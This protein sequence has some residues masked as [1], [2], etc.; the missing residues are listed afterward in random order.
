LNRITQA[1]ELGQS[2]WLD[3]IRRDLVEDG[4][5]DRL[6][7]AGEIRGVT[8]NPT[9]FQQ[10]IGGG[11]L[12]NAAIRPLAHAGWSA[13]QIYEALAIHDIRA[14]TDLFLPL[15]E[16]TNAR[17]GYVSIEVNPRLANDSEATIEEARRLW[18]QVN[19][20]NLMVKIPATSGGIPAI[21]QSIFE[22]INV[23]VT[24]IFALDR[25]SEVMDA[26]LSGL[27]RRLEEGRPLERIASVASFFVSR[28]DT[29][30]DREL[31]SIVREEGPHASRAMTLLG[32]AAVANAKLAYAQFQSVFGDPRFD[33][34]AEHGARLQ[35][36]LWASTST[37]NAAY[38]DVLYVDELIGPDTVNTLPPKTLEAFR[39]H[40][41]AQAR[42][43]EDLAVARAQLEA[44]EVLGVSMQQVTDRLESE[45][46][47]AFVQSFDDLIETVG[48]RADAMRRELGGL[49]S[50]LENALNQLEEQRAAG[51]YWRKDLSLWPKARESHKPRIAEFGGGL[52]ELA[53][54]I[55]RIG[56]EIHK[57]TLRR[58]AWIGAHA[59]PVLVDSRGGA[60]TNLQIETAD[61]LEYRGLSRDATAVVALS[62]TMQDPL[63]TAIV[64]GLLNRLEK[65]SSD[66][67]GDR[68]V[69][70][71]PPDSALDGLAQERGFGW[72][73]NEG[74]AAAVLLQADLAAGN[75]AEVVESAASMRDA[76][77]QIREAARNPGLYLGATLAVAL[78]QGYARIGLVADEAMAPAARWLADRL[79]TTGLGRQVNVV[80]H[81]P[82]AT[83]QPDRLLIYLRS[84]GDL[85]AQVDGWIAAGD[86]VV[87]LEVS[88]VTGAIGG[89][90]VRW[91]MASAIAAYLMQTDLF[92][93][94]VQDQVTDRLAGLIRKRRKG[95]LDLPKPTW[96]FEQNQVWWPQKE[97][98]SL[99]VES[100][101]GLLEQ[102]LAGM[103]PGTLI[104]LG[105]YR[106]RTKAIM[107]RLEQLR[108]S[109]SQHRQLDCRAAFGRLPTSTR[110]KEGTSRQA[111]MLIEEP[112]HKDHQVA[113]LQL[114]Y[115]DLQRASMLAAVDRLRKG[116]ESV[117]A[118][119]L[120]SID[121]ETW[122]RKFAAIAAS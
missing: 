34:L 58:V 60:E 95:R 46:V 105:I 69:A 89:E 106:R 51:R 84:E 70:I 87:I 18:E 32:S 78:Q 82:A 13:N 110:E 3:Y 8:S 117:C 121:T 111:F 23:N 72:V 114:G 109:L 102:L 93:E 9:I 56:A 80:P 73:L 108:Q 6:I 42:L 81:L 83:D 98:A 113:S 88:M 17:D 55:A 54:R 96:E 49:Q 67:A 57:S 22:G 24:L 104:N 77:A 61:P 97:S 92:P 38:S 94:T 25:Y 112:P 2:F 35:R 71:A 39:D 59:L 14:A 101:D 120:G 122:L 99:E 52:Q 103:L 74:T 79:A 76:C 100:L 11:D 16:G 41:T 47:Q 86:P 116:R 19:R 75:L 7:K 53:E 20:P 33:H 1:L 28:V 43:E 26:Y 27:E 44:V 62:D 91:D 29:A 65:A 115:G 4:E 36:P 48:E 45:G 119:T 37:K 118:M 30:V 50:N 85:D 90:A 68:F 63:A 10:A 31:E 64:E 40:G 21:E 66:R 107:K 15:Y 12:Y 5:L